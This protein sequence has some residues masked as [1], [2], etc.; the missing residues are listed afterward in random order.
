MPKI[1]L[2]VLAVAAV[3][4]WAVAFVFFDKSGDLVG[5]LE[6]SE[7]ER[8][9]LAEDLE[10]ARKDL[11][12]YTESAGRLDEIGEEVRAAEDRVAA[13]EGMGQAARKELATVR[14]DAEAGKAELATVESTLRERKAE[15]G[16]IEQEIER[17]GTELELLRAATEEMRQMAEPAETGQAVEGQ[18]QTQAASEAEPRVAEA[19]QTDRVAE[20]KRRFQIVDQNGDGELAKFEFR[21]NSIKLLGV[22]DANQDG[23]V[24]RDETFLSPEQFAL[25]EFN[26]DG[27]ISPLEFVD[28]RTFRNIDADKQ[29][30]ITFEEYMTF[31]QGTAP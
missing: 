21:L 10:S 20:A 17:A 22:I 8:A 19:K 7:A 1:L 30:S 27:K 14:N 29:G 25:F 3:A 18:P 6:N 15:V 2:G 26:G 12:K 31:V 5:K 9:K 13:L 4:G 28:E 11:G 23:F 24:T 16:E